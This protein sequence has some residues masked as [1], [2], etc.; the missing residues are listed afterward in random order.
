MAWSRMAAAIIL[1]GSMVGCFVETVDD[2]RDN[3]SARRLTYDSRQEIVPESAEAGECR[4][5]AQ[6]GCFDGHII[7]K[8]EFSVEGKTFFNADD[9][10]TRF[11]ELITV[12]RL[13]GETA[14]ENEYHI[15]LLTAL[16]NSSFLHTFEYYLSGATVRSGNVRNNGVFNINELNEGSYELRLQKSIQFEVIKT[17]AEQSE[18]APISNLIE[19]PVAVLA[20]ANSTDDAQIELKNSPVI[21]GQA[22]ESATFALDAR[23][24]TRAKVYCATLYAD[25][26]VDVRRGQRLW[27]PFNDFRLHVI[28]RECPQRGT[29]RVVTF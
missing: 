16:D 23:A 25:K 17:Q 10:A 29:G 2:N 18:S 5:T 7:A 19:H 28:D 15:R 9:F 22:E 20:D 14:S 12:E 6:K 1:G 3:S 27:E 26:A 4:V 13:G 24:E 8:K 21:S 11:A